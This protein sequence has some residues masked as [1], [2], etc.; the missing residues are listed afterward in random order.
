MR[1]LTRASVR[2]LTNHRLQSLLSVLGV[3]LGVAVVLSIDMAIESSREGFRVSA[4]TVAGTATHVI[5][6]EAG[7]LDEDLIRVLRT[8]LGVRA[9]APV[10]EGFARSDRIPGR[11]L[12]VLG[13]DPFSEAPFRPWVAGGASGLDVSIGLT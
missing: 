13:I 4:E 1:L 9:A 12:R 3:A 5:V 6:S 11:A 8:E 7:A 10:V 2:H